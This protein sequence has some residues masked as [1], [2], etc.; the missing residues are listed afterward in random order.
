MAPITSVHHLSLTVTDL[1]RSVEWYT[2]LLG[3]SIEREVQGATFR[4]TRLRH[5]D[6]SVILTL[7]QHHE[8]SLETFRE[9]TT[10]LDHLAFLVPTV[11][12]VE[13]CERL[14]EDRGVPHSEVKRDALDVARIFFRDP[15]NIQLEVIAAPLRR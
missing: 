2:Q 3:F 7:T 10:G 6:T 12:D 9:T 4:R 8:G 13:A 1:S 5:T 14:F 11:A 15:D